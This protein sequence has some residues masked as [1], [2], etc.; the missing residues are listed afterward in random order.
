MKLKLITSLL[1]VACATSLPAAITITVFNYAPNGI[2]SGGSGS[3]QGAISSSLGTLNSAGT[4][5]GMP[6]TT[7]TV[8]N[9]NLTSLG[10]TASESFTF[11]VSYAQTGGTAVQ[12]NGFGNV[13]VTG[14]DN[15]QVDTTETLTAVIALTSSSFPGLSL[16]GFTKARA[17][18]FAVNELGTFTWATGSHTVGPEA[19]KTIASIDPLDGIGSVTLSVTTGNLNFEGF[20]AQFTAV[21]EPGTYAALTGLGA[22]ALVALRRHRKRTA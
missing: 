22:L 21:P 17:G 15:N 19:G 4:N 13:S 20:E 8:S 12:F 3:G 6:V 14:G 11:T 5:R 9:V 10:G 16:D 2:A 7:Y 18:G 1:A